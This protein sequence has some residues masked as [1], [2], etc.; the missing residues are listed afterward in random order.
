LSFHF[1]DDLI[2]L[3][4]LIG[5]WLKLGGLLVFSVRHPVRT[6]NPNGEVVTTNGVSWQL[7]N[8]FAEGP[9]EFRWL[10]AECINY[11]RTLSTYLRYVREAGLQLDTLEEPND[12]G[13]TYE[14][15]AESCSVPF[16]LTI[17]ARKF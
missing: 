5:Y 14:F 17:A 3:L 6:A 7:N 11:H 15:S 12:L 2:A 1:V 8:Y 13:Q 16:L 4:K 9:R 10:G